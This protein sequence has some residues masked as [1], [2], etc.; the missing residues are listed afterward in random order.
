M[1]DNRSLAVILS[2][3]TGI[4]GLGVTTERFSPHIWAHSV[5]QKMSWASRRVCTRGEDQAY[6]LMGLFRVNMPLLY[7]EGR[8]H[9]FQRLQQEIL[10]TSDDESIF[11]W[12]DHYHENR[13]RVLAES[14]ADFANSSNI[15]RG[16]WIYG[17]P[18]FT[19]TSKGLKLETSLLHHVS[20]TD[21]KDAQH[22]LYPFVLNCYV[23]GNPDFPF[24]VFL[25][26]YKDGRF[27]RYN[28]VDLQRQH[29]HRGA[30]KDWEQDNLRGEQR[31][32]YWV[33]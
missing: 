31:V 1:G 20:W 19:V 17:R 24:V 14:P 8:S 6:C 29:G 7:G 16:D 21:S 15:V 27:C 13:I 2:E 10:K 9:A 18:D 5:A 32:I 25:D 26:E 11:A 12:C 23:D 3:I 28:S 4:R 22:L 30:Q 33:L